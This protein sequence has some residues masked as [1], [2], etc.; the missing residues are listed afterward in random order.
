MPTIVE[1]R[2]FAMGINYG[3]GE[4]VLGDAAKAGDRLRGSATL[5]DVT[6]VRGGVQ[7]RMAIVVESESAGAVCTI[8][9][10]SR[11]LHG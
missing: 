11:W 8:E 3:T 6:D 7:T 10:L 4:I 9:S 5:L 2:G 1:V